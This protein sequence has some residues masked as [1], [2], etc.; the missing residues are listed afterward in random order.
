MLVTCGS[1]GVQVGALGWINP[2][3]WQ[4]HTESWHTAL[5]APSRHGQGG[6]S[7]PWHSDGV[8]G[9]PRSRCEVSLENISLLL[10]PPERIALAQAENPLCPVLGVTSRGSGQLCTRRGAG[11]PEV[12]TFSAAPWIALPQVLPWLLPLCSSHLSW[13]KPHST[14]A[15]LTFPVLLW[16]RATPVPAV[17]SLQWHTRLWSHFSRR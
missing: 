9:H 1:Q 2:P 13:N 6:L 17:T 15:V 10:Q 8:A 12:Q 11:S 14:P 16:F 7:S 3:A 5:L 4:G